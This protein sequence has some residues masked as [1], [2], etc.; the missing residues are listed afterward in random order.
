VPTVYANRFA[1]ERRA[2]Y[3]LYNA[4]YRTARGELLRV[5]RTEGMRCTDAF[6]GKEI[7]LVG[8]D[9]TA[10]VTMALGPHEVGCIVVEKR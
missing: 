2:V 10:T 8:E 3:T 6:T 1:G 9:G 7:P 4:G 5:P